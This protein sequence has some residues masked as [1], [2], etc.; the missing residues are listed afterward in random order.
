M[1]QLLKEFYALCPDGICDRDSL[2]EAERTEMAQGAMYLTGIL[3]RHSVENGNR[4]VY[5]KEVLERED[6]NY[7]MLIRQNRALGCLDHDDGDT[8]LLKESSHIVV[9]TWWDGNALMGK[10]KLLNTPN[11]K[12]AQSLVRDGVTLGISSRGMGSIK[13]NNGKQIV[14]NDFILICYDLVTTPSTPGAF[15]SEGLTNNKLEEQKLLKKLTKDDKVV[16]IIDSIL[17]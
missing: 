6:K 10:I 7:Q 1:R 5:P 11:G 2:T 8:V 9:A 17:A 13:E 15:L 14:D 12:I 16:R 4:R 3:Q